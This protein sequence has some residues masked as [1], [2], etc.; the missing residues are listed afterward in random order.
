MVIV[1]QPARRPADSTA[2]HDHELP[3]NVVTFIVVA[4]HNGMSYE[5]I[6][7]LMNRIGLPSAR[8]GQWYGSTVA[9]VARRHA[10]GLAAVTRR[11]S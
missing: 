4:R 5:R 8:G 10:I 6:A 3:D 2:V 9:R 7:S 1:L 11:A